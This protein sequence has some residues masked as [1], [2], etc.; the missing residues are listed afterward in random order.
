MP[1]DNVIERPQA[2]PLT[3]RRLRE[4]NLL[5]PLCVEH[6]TS[7]TSC[8]DHMVNPPQGEPPLLRIG[9]GSLR[10]CR[11]PRTSAD[12][13]ILRTVDVWIILG[14]IAGVVAIFVAVAIAVWL[15]RAANRDSQIDRS[16]ASVERERE[17]LTELLEFLVN[18]RVLWARGDT[19]YWQEVISSVLEIRRRVETVLGRVRGDDTAESLLRLIN[20]SCLTLLDYRCSRGDRGAGI[21]VDTFYFGDLS[22]LP[23]RRAVIGEFR[24]VVRPAVDRLATLLHL[25]THLPPDEGIF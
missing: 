10:N 16:E 19:E 11:K 18:R 5:Y 6:R 20:E 9:Q 14:S 25:A 3:P 15:R 8:L 13:T 1:F 2:D 21:P 12:S 4:Q 23:E 24:Q 22:T 7:L 17:D